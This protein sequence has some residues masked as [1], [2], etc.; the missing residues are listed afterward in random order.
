MKYTVTEEKIKN[1]VIKY[2]DSINWTVIKN[3]DNI[4]PFLVFEHNE[5]KQP[6]LVVQCITHRYGESCNLL[7][8]SSFQERLEQLFGEENVGLGYYDEPNT[9]VMDWFIKQ[10]KIQ[11]DDYL[12][13]GSEAIF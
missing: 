3:E 1:I 4:Y 5:D 9:L 10:F 13:V 6:M 8:R 11:V 12:Y 2:L 7:I